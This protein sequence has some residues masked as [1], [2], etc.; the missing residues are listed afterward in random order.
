M[1]QQHAEALCLVNGVVRTQETRTGIA[2]GTV[3]RVGRIAFVG[4][5]RDCLSFA[6]RPRHVIDLGGKVV[7]PGFIDNHTHFVMGGQQ[8]LGI[9]LRECRSP[10]EFR[11]RLREF[12]SR[13]RSNWITG[14]RWDQEKWAGR[15]LPTKTL[16]DNVTT[17]TPVFVQRIDGH[18]GLANS[19]ALHLA[20]ITSAT[21]DP[22]GGRIL[23]DAATGHPTGILKD[24]AMDLVNAVIPRQTST[25]L[26]QAVLAAQRHAAEVGITSVHDITQAEDLEAY[27]RLE[28]AGEL[29]VRIYS[30]LPLA[31][32]DSLVREGVRA[33]TG[34]DFL[35]RGSLKAFADG[36]LGA[37]T[38][39]FFNPYLHEPDNKGLATQAL[40]RGDLRRWAIEADRAG[41]Q[42]S[43]HAIGD[44]ANSLVLEIYD[45]ITR[46]QKPWDRRFRMEHAQHVRAEDI[47]A[48][49][50]LQVIVSAQPYHAYDDGPWAEQ[51][52]GK[53]RL[54]TTYAFRSFLRAGVMVCFGSDW[55]VAP[56]SPLL[57]I[58]AAVT[59]QTADGKNPE[60]WIPE[61]KLS[62]DE[63]IRCY[64]I[65]NAFAAFEEDR[66]G[67]IRVGNVADLVVLSDDIY[68]IDPREIRN[69]RVQMTVVDGRIIIDNSGSSP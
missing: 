17:D 9:D 47:P 31:M 59:R 35:T 53:E 42:L 32:V 50:R 43:I 48:F 13:R 38:A 55:P 67:S 40:E 6:G 66:K 4:S 63:A 62:V 65:N 24:S 69:V 19:L 7:L 41:L 16:I 26:Q 68:A 28:S 11:V 37:N 52:L 64:T 57:G 45:E 15:E 58:H 61:Q 5:S 29:T 21:P 44:R 34:S 49:R 33:G 14:G 46:T 60:G 23:R 2:Q 1:T 20:G 25:D 10:E 8:L 22:D 39:L 56:L 3:T 36:S 27:R 30:R 18:V 12:A 51:R 54:A